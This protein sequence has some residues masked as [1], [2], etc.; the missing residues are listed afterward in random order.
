MQ[1]TT[2]N[3]C[4][5]WE[6]NWSRPSNALIEQSNGYIGICNYYV[7]E[8]R[9][10]SGSHSLSMYMYD[11]SF[12]TNRYNSLECLTKQYHGNPS[13]DELRFTRT[14]N[15]CRVIA[16]AEHRSQ[17]DSYS[18]DSFD[19]MMKVSYLQLWR[20]PLSLSYITKWQCLLSML[21]P[22]RN[23]RQCKLSWRYRKGLLPD[24]ILVICVISKPT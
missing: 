17:P 11:I 4:Y 6:P 21:M 3:I 9:N 5:I 16:N 8:G 18:H 10:T 2:K 13:P 20:C 7:F 14:I 15:K 23:K 1:R 24:D 19:D 22:Q 12:T